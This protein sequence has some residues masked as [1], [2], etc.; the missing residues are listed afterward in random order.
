MT[1]ESEHAEK[2][3]LSSILQEPAQAIPLCV[4][5]IQPGYFFSPARALIYGEV[6][7]MWS[8]SEQIDNVTLTQRLI[9]RDLLKDVG[10]PAEIAE[11][12]Y[13]VPS[14]AMLDDYI[15]I[16]REKF[17][18]RRITGICSSYQTRA[19][20]SEDPSAL[21]AELQSELLRLGEAKQEIRSTPELVSEALS[22]IERAA[23][24][25]LLGLSSGFIDLDHKTG[26]MKPGQL[27][28]I[29]ADTSQGKTTLALNIAEHCA[30]ELQ[31]PVGI[32]SLEMAGTELVQRLFASV[33][34]VDVHNISAGK[35]NH[36]DFA[37]I[38]RAASKVSSAPVWIRDES[39]VDPIKLRA[40]GRQLRQQNRVEL[41]VVDY[42][43]LL[44]PATAKDD[45][46]ERA[47][48]NAAQSLKQ[49]AKEL[50]VVVVGLS[51]L[52]DSGK[53]RE[54]RA[55]GHHADKVITITHDED[56]QGKA[57][58]RVD[59]NRSG[60]TGT[61]TVT[62]LREFTRFVNAKAA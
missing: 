20:K 15:T 62:F 61:V 27:I 46:R 7:A 25:E 60:P 23:A 45:S 6:V 11:L 5:K 17:L 26:P 12:T 22:D 16:L 18:A 14:A 40:I 33:G 10:G 30:I 2:A 39:D 32:I 43:Q 51:Q 53:L 59:K 8:A 29:A 3:V 4:E 54:S 21:L 37:R 48:S 52:N 24:G 56:E 57:Y 34:M 42:I 49:M 1:P 47:M 28:V 41:I 38:T 19:T 50:G 13:Y 35:G 44:T 55:I 9:N 31:R 58:L 36:D